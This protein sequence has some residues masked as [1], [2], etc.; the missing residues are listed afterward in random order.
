MDEFFRVRVAD[1]KRLM[2][3]STGK[4]KEE[5]EKLYDQLQKKVNQ[6]QR[7]FD[8]DYLNTMQELHQH[9]IYLIDESQIQDAQIPFITDYFQQHIQPALQP[10]L[11]TDSSSQMPSLTDGSF[12]LGIK[13][14]LEGDQTRYGV[15]EVPAPPLSRFVVIPT[16]K[17]SQDKVLIVLENII[18]YCLKDV[19]RGTLGIKKASAYVFKLTRDAE[20]ELGEGISQSLIDKMSNSLQKRKSGDPVRFVYDKQMPEDLLGFLVRQLGFGRYDSLIAGG[21]YHN[22][23]DFM[24]FP[25]LGPAALEYKKQPVI[26]I[27]FLDDTDLIFDAIKEKDIMLHFPYHPFYYVEDLLYTAALDPAVRSIKITLYRLASDSHIISAL[28]N[29]ASN[30][31]KVTVVVELQARFDEQANIRWANH[32]TESGVEVIFGIPGLK[33]HSKL[34]LIERMEGT[35]IKYYSH[36]GTGNFNE[37]TAR[38]YTDLSLLT[39]HQE[40]G[41]EVENIFEFI[42]HTYKQFSFKHLMVSPYGFRPGITQLIEQ[43]TENARQGKPA[44]I[45]LKCNNLVDTD[46][47]KQLYEAS[48]AGVKIRLIIRGMMSLVPGQAGFSENI[49]A[50]SIVDRFLE[51]A[52]IYIFENDGEPLMF[53]GSGDVMTRNLD[54]R[55]EVVCPVYDE[56]IKHLINGI[57]ETQWNDN[58]KARLINKK[59]NNEIRQGE[60]DK[61]VRA[62]TEIHKKV[63][64]YSK[65]LSEQADD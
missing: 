7:R 13:L 57:I 49:E 29:A 42:Q 25:N 38:V 18:R 21:R 35:T 28:I 58:Q 43:E 65:S 24:K 56:N 26:N 11:F 30:N 20:L 37:S 27:P 64:A 9:H 2:S 55:V 33:V 48:N 12:Y 45:T 14:I 5:S 41:K 61:T 22:F 52:R 19:F 53:F 32:L 36:I 17:G 8:Q 62:Q 23:K 4:A 46:I 54:Y 59:L 44:S 1:L 60:E 51:H 15:L 63:L 47:V 3:F 39:Y 31:K 16:T 34:I 50:I 6:L 40:I 10:V